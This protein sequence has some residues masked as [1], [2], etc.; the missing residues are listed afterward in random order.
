MFVYGTWDTPVEVWSRF[1]VVQ[2][3][4]SC[5]GDTTTSALHVS[6]QAG[7]QDRAAE[8]GFIFLA[9][10][11]TKGGTCSELSWSSGVHCKSI[12]LQDR[13]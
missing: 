3:S 9:L 11:K 8:R 1:L 4:G 5:T 10:R 13:L 7:V 6:L 2:K 12:S